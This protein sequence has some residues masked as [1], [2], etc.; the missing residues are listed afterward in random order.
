MAKEIHIEKYF[1]TIGQFLKMAD[2]VQTGGA[3]KWFLQ[4]NAV[5]VNGER[6]ERRGRKLSDGDFI[7]VPGCGSFIIKGNS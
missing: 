5:Y 4:E 2:I 7:R 6:E 1:I 3:A